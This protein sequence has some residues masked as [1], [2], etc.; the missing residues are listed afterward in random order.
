MAPTVRTKIFVS[1]SRKDKR[2]LEDLHTHLAPLA[3]QLELWDDSRQTSGKLWR[4]Q[5]E[6]ALADCKAAVLLVSPDFLA[7][8]F[9]AESE[10]SPLLAAADATGVPLLCIY[11]RPSSVAARRFSYVDPTTGERRTA[12]LDEFQGA[13]NPD[14]PLSTMPKPK[15]EAEI[16]KVV[17][18]ILAALS[19]LPQHRKPS[20]QTAGSRLAHAAR[21]A[22]PT[23]DL[24]DVLASL[25]VGTFDAV[26]ERAGAPPAAIPPSSESVPARAFYLVQ[27]AEKSPHNQRALLA[28]LAAFGRG[29]APGPPAAPA[30][31]ELV[32]LPRIAMPGAPLVFISYSHADEAWKERLGTQLRV[33]QLHGGLAVWDDRR[34]EFGD[35]WR[36][37]IDQALV[38]ARVAILL[39]SARFLTSKFIN[40][41][42]V[43]R[44]L[45]R[46]AEEGLRVV[47]VIAEP[48]LWQDVA[49]LSRMQAYPRD[50]RPLAGMSPYAAD[51]ALVALARAVKRWAVAPPATVFPPPLAAHARERRPRLERRQAP[52][53]APGG[54]AS[55]AAEELAHVEARLYAVRKRKRAALAAGADVAAL[56]KQIRRLRRRQRLGPRLRC[57]DTLSRR[58]QLLEKLGRGGFATVW[59]ALDLREDRVVAVKVLHHDLAEEKSRLRRFFR[60]AKRMAE[61]NHPSVVKVFR[62][63]CEDGHWLFFVME[64]V[65]G[66]DLHRAVAEG[67]VSANDVPRLVLGVAEA[68]AHAH[69]AGLVHRDVTPS[70]ILLDSQSRPHL[71]DF[72]LVRAAGT[73]GGTRT[74]ALGKFLYAAPE[75]LEAGKDADARADVYSLGVVAIYALSG[76]VR[77]LLADGAACIDRLACAVQVKSVLR[78]AVSRRP[79]DRYE[80]AGA[81][82]R[83]WGAAIDGNDG[84]VADAAST[85]APDD[86]RV[87]L[88]PESMDSGVEN[89]GAAARENLQQHA[90]LTR[91]VARTAVDDMAGFDPHDLS[92]AGWAVIFAEGVD[93]SVRKALRPLLDHRRSQAGGLFREFAGPVGYRL[94]D[95]KLSFLARHGVGPG[96][97]D[98]RQIPYYVLLVGSGAEIPFAFQ[99]QLDVQ[100]AVG[101]LAFDH[102][103]QYRRYAEGVLDVEQG[104]ACR[105]RRVAV[106]APRNEGDAVGALAHDRLA[107]PLAQAIAAER[108]WALDPALGEQA[109]RARLL[110]LLGAKAPALLLA[111]GHGA[112][113]ARGDA[114]QHALQGALVCQEWRKALHPAPARSDVVAGADLAREADLRGLVVFAMA[115]FSA[116][117]PRHSA[118]VSLNATR[119][120]ELADADFVAR[121]P[122]R[123]LSHPGGPALAVVGH[124]DA[125]FSHGFAWLPE[126]HQNQTFMIATQHLMGGAP[127]GRAMDCFGQRY[128]ELAAA[129]AD[130]LS[131]RLG[132]PADPEEVQRIWQATRDAGGYVLL[133][134]PAA[135]VGA[136]AAPQ[137]SLT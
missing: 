96:P 122:Q 45:R 37:D 4:P 119:P 18:K 129:L 2:W 26:L 68:L 87:S 20:L 125:A 137:A 111:V 114:H 115:S 105:P 124:V 44:A 17:Q 52:H 73:T 62:K 126:G 78:R 81:F 90:N 75:A 51:M 25:A 91:R 55:R 27:W 106:F 9:I 3:G 30:T 101:R 61:L 89:T 133:G 84:S 35:D 13:N 88:P 14:R 108:G 92:Q 47:P 69:A 100:Y 48:C 54:A 104:R 98:P 8:R 130:L 77:A 64:Y 65:D 72:D 34:I 112:H 66:G 110:E 49:W 21:P 19:G 97:V 43:P 32:A 39:I 10:V 33:L 99:S 121:L 40:D 28:A 136:E 23:V 123:L 93:A 86:V 116:G 70:N 42:E 63:R 135:R 59:R 1:Y 24:L 117:T 11:V 134:D 118:F 36:P 120:C 127:V 113:V 41:V 12:T 46:R 53:S 6:A 57:K 107:Q 16:V 67:R 128:A 29:N 82:A 7:S 15:R 95:T 109:T 103:S 50:G 38:S 58:Y 102:V 94:G 79:E 22:T 74:G 76:D 80:D 132:P 131:K 56:E 85:Q 60:G 31:R 71:T 83:A 5:I